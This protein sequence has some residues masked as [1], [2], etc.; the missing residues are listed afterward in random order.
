[1]K[2]GAP[3]LGLAKSISETLIRK[4]QRVVGFAKTL[5]SISTTGVNIELYLN[6]IFRPSE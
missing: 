1:M 3:L 2:S 6:I 5:N 4:P